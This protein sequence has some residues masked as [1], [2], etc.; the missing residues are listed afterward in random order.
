LHSYKCA[1]V[2]QWVSIPKS[3]TA[4][5]HVQLVCQHEGKINGG[6]SSSGSN[7]IAKTLY[8]RDRW[9]DFT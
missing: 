8:Q 2:I 5:R 3:T 1:I 4:A 7:E 6:P 9:N